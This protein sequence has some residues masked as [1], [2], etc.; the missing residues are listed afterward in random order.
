MKV[1]DFIKTTQ[2]NIV[3]INLQ[4]D[5][6]KFKKYLSNEFNKIPKEFLNLE[7]IKIVEANNMNEVYVAEEF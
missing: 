2:K 3:L 4:D 5:K 1:K 6:M 7:I